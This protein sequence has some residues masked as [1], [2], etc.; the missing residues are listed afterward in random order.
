M[1]RRPPRSTRTDTL[2]PYTTLFRS[3]TIHICTTPVIVITAIA[4]A[5]S[6]AAMFVILSTLRGSVRSAMPPPQSP[7]RSTGRNW[8]DT[9]SP[10]P[11]AP[12]EVEHEPCLGRHLGQGAGPGDHLTD[13]GTLVV[14]HLET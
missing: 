14:T 13:A 10:T 3:R 6:A 1:I 12:A 5:T 8:S 7:K 11:E 9:V 4:T 2:F